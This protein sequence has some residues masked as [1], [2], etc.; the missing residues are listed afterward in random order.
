MF[1]LR[2]K[3]W[4]LI[5]YPDFRSQL[6]N[7]REDPGENHDYALGPAHSET[8]ESLTKILC[9]VLN[10]KKVNLQAFQDQEEKIAELGG[11]ESILSTQNFDHTPVKLK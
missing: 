3:D 8:I 1:M 11:R 9:S 7:L 10:P 5:V 6:F 2:Y 4:K